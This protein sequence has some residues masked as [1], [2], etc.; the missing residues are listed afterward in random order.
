VTIRGAHDG[1]K[2]MIVFL[3]CGY[4]GSWWQRRIHDPRC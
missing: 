4:R 2:I 1:I 3:S